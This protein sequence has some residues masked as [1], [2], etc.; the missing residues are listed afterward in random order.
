M[1]LRFD[2]RK[3]DRTAFLTLGAFSLYES[4]GS[5]GKTLHELI[6]VRVSQMNGCA[7]CLEMHTRDA[8]KAGE[9]EA[10]LYLL[11]A[12]RESTLYTPPER[13]ALALAE[14]VTQI[15]DGG[16][17]QATYEAARAHFSEKQ[18]L[19]LIMAVIAINSWNRIAIAT[20]MT[21]R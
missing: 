14:E 6:K 3:V 5:L 1:S 13:A 16:V 12:W 2:Y 18:V 8:R 17:S 10:R 11:N 4:K 15:A 7:F 21:N 9:E 19:E 20:G